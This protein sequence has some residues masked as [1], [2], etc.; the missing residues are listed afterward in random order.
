MHERLR[1]HAMSAWAAVQ[2]GQANPLVELV[3]DDLALQ[4][5]LSPDKIRESMDVGGHLGDAP[6][7]ARQLAESARQAVG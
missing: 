3:A 2:A 7:R 1:Q 6:Q 5:Y 4:A